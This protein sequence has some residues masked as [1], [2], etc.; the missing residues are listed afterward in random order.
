MNIVKKVGT[1]WSVGVEQPR[2]NSHAVVEIEGKKENG[3]ILEQ[4]GFNNAPKTDK[5]IAALQYAVLTGLYYLVDGNQIVDFDT[6]A[7]EILTAAP[8]GRSEATLEDKAIGIVLS[9]LAKQRKCKVS[10]LEDKAGEKI[11]RAY[12]KANMALIP[13]LKA[14]YD[15]AFASLQ[16]DDDF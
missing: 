2:R 12:V 5:G 11:N 16:D 15:A 8:R 6:M 14:L 13:K 4:L 1:S 9:A 3:D 10:E 7:D